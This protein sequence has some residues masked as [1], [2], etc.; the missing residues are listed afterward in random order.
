MLYERR[1][2]SMTTSK[3]GRR[4]EHDVCREIHDTDCGLSAWP[5]GWSGNNSWPSPDIMVTDGVFI[6]GIE[7]KVTGQEYVSIAMDEL[8][9][10][11]ELRPVMRPYI[12]VSFNYREPMLAAVPRDW[13]RVTAA[14]PDA[15]DPRITDDAVLRFSRPSTDEWA[16]AQEGDSAAT[17]IATCV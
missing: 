2:S 3:K 6:G 11:H 5:I 15:F 10:L 13:K 1:A 14:V 4:F 17:K 16:S 7:L 9:Q 12:C 8:Q